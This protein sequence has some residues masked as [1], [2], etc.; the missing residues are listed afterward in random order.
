[1]RAATAGPL[2]ELSVAADIA[3][4]TVERDELQERLRTVSTGTDFN[5]GLFEKL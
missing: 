4:L 2:A 1:M 3:A 5:F